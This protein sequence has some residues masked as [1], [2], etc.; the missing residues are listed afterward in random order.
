MVDLPAGTPLSTD[1]DRGFPVPITAFVDDAI[2]GVQPE[3]PQNTTINRVYTAFLTLRKESRILQGTGPA[4]QGADG[5]FSTDEKQPQTGNIIEYR[6]TY[7]NISEAQ[8][9]TGNVIL[10]AS[11]VQ[12]VENGIANG[13]NW[14]LDN[15]TNGVIDTSNV[16]GSAT[17]TGTVQFFNGNPVTL[18]T[19]QT[20]TTAAT[21][22]TQYINNVGTVQPTVN[23]TFIFQRRVN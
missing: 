13:N 16:V 23:G 1:I 8:S 21:D 5:T 20:G 14:A 2:P 12:I 15:D 22:V 6:I 9:G 3:E 11:N 7:T 10:P 19:D 17:G 18:G 4:V